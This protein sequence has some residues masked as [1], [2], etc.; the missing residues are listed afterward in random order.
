MTKVR[1]EWDEDKNRENKKK[2][3]VSFEF[4]QYAFADPKRVIAEDMKHSHGEKRYYCIGK[5]GKGV[6]TVR[7]TYR[8]DVIRIIDAGY[9][10]GGKK[11]YE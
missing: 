11:I 7:F 4:A 1:F 10:R 2:H 6:L 8:N 5:V 9:W 3:S